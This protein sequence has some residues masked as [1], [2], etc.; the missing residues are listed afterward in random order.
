[1]QAN[2]L[3][4]YA[5][6][7]ARCLSSLVPRNRHLSPQHPLNADAHCTVTTYR[8]HYCSRRAVSGE[9]LKAAGAA[10][11]NQCGPS[12]PTTACM[13]NHLCLFSSTYHRYRRSARWFMW[14]SLATRSIVGTAYGTTIWAIMAAND[15][16]NANIYVGQ[17]RLFQLARTAGIRYPL[18]PLRSALCARRAWAGDMLFSVARAGNHHRRG[19]QAGWSHLAT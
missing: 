18:R 16:S 2:G 15:L 11:W 19:T 14:C 4:D 5:I 13:D 12:W 17:S 3:T 7:A 10:V 9:T 6:K 1:M 8:R